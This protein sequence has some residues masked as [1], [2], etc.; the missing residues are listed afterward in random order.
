M[1]S[2]RVN[3]VL[4][5]AFVLAMLIATVAAVAVLSGRTG[6][7]ET[8]FARFRDVSEIRHGTLVTYMGY[9]VGQVSAVHPRRQDG[10][11]RFDV[12]LAVREGWPIPADSRAEVRTAGLLTAVT[13]DIRAGESEERIAPG[14]RIATAERVSALAAVTET[15]NTFRELTESEVRPLLVN[16]RR[17]V[18][19]FGGV[20]ESEGSD[21]VRNV[22]AI[23]GELAT[24]GPEMIANFLEVSREFNETARRLQAVLG[25]ENT[26]R[27]DAILA[28]A[29]SA[30]ANVAALTADERLGE[31]L[32]NIRAASTSLGRLTDT[33]GRRLDEVLG[34]DTT[35]RLRAAL[36]N[37]AGA[38]GNVARLTADLRATREKLDRFV[39]TLESAALENRPRLERSMRDLQHSMEVVARHIDAIAYNLEGTSRN[40]HEFSRQV[41]QNP[42]LLLGGGTPV[43]AAQ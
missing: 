34:A 23:T 42:G 13:I 25:P 33:A 35:A 40:M 36:D 3:Y 29:E 39:S 27:I 22:S 8:Y 18:D 16:L 43:D 32:E 21:L 15:A 19:A 7:T 31:T 26:G 17:Y 28:N 5:G 9:R 12:E 6:P 1:T 20:L 30:S 14:A 24:H 37:V 38:A 10:E 4:V 41:R 11:L 2:A